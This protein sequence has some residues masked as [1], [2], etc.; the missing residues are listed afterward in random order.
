MPISFATHPAIEDTI[1]RIAAESIL[2]QVGRDDG[3]V[4][5]FSLLGDLVD[6]CASFAEFV[7]FSVGR[8][9]ITG[10][11]IGVVACATIDFGAAAAVPP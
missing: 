7:G 4:P 3:L 6:L 11:P 8:N 1:N 5:A 10:S 9:P 2:A